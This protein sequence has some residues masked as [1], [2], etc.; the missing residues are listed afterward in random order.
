MN[1]ISNISTLSAI[2]W[3]ERNFNGNNCT[4][5]FVYNEAIW[6]EKIL[7]NIILKNLVLKIMFER[8]LKLK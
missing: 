4:K 6:V 2:E 8:N 1:N 3:V 5:V 7:N